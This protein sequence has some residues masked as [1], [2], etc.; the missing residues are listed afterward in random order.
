MLMISPQYPSRQYDNRQI[1][2]PNE[3]AGPDNSMIISTRLLS[4]QSAH[5]F[6]DTVL[7]WVVRVVFAGDFEDGREGVSEGVYTVTNA[8]RDL[9]MCQMG[10]S[11]A[12]LPG[13]RTNM[14]V[15]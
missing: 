8:L 10:V 3:G 15:D 1:W 4:K 14:L 6:E 5:T 12:D 9:Y 2:T 11:H 7:F 13:T